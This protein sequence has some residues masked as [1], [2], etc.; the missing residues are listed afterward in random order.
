MAIG[1]L[2]ALPFVVVAAGLVQA[3]AFFWAS[4][5]GVPHWLAVLGSG[6][7]GLL[8]SA[9]SFMVLR[10]CLQEFGP[11]VPVARWPLRLAP[12]VL[13]AAALMVDG[14]TIGGWIVLLILGAA[15]GEWVV[16]RW[17]ARGLDA[18]RL[19][20]RFFLFAFA[21]LAWLAIARW[22]LNTPRAEH[23]LAREQCEGAYARARTPI[24][25]AMLDHRSIS[26]SSGRTCAQLRF[27]MTRP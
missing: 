16:H 11:G 24:D 10:L 14:F 23:A 9:L 22:L 26:P 5:P 19:F 18:S 8:A 15:A 2:I 12:L 13:S 3:L 7:V 25:S 20:G 6:I 1:Y 17:L 21:G 4:V 27:G